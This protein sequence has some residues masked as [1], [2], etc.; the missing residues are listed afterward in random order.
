[1]SLLATRMLER[2]ASGNLDK[3]EYRAAQVGALDFIARDTERPDSIATEEMKQK[4]RTAFSTDVKVPVINYDS[5]VSIGNVRSHTVADSLN[6]SALVTITSATYTFGFTQAPALYMNNEISGQ[7][8]FNVNMEKYELKLMDTLNA[9]ATALLE[10][11]KTQVLANDL[12]YAVSGNTVNFTAAQAD[13]AFG[14]VERMQRSNKYFGPMHVIG[15]RG[16]DS[17]VGNL[18]QFSTYNT[19]NKALEFKN[20][21]F[22]YTDAIADAADKKATGYMIAP[23]STAMMFRFDREAELGTV[24]QH[25]GYTWG[26]NRLPMT[27]IP[28]G[29]ME[30]ESVGDYSSTF[31]AATADGKA[32]R[33]YHFGFSVDIAFMFAYNS[34]AANIA[35]P[36][37]KFDIATT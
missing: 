16:V 15:N 11:N 26:I 4:F 12:N 10:S 31:G 17:V 21:T 14:E 33:K 37:I 29:T 25:S 2:R 35:S 7:R 36:C 19:Q 3:W 18:E 22:H 24:S 13:K 30:Y 6:T 27:G 1:M 20:K 9:V 32:I 5:G 28:V 8:D 34:D 23:G